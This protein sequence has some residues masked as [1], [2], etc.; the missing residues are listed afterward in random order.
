MY[1]VDHLLFTFAIGIRTYFQKVAAPEDIAPSMAVGFTI[2]HV[3][4]VILP[5][6]GGAL[7]ML[8][9]RIPFL[10]GA[11]FSLVSLIAVQRI[12]PAEPLASLQST[13]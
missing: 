6:L 8:D 12:P 1:V 10:A 11:A 5:A 2:N 9:Y 7:W 13:S 4:A 3:A